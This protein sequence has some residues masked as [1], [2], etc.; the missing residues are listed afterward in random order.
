MSTTCRKWSG[1]SFSAGAAGPSVRVEL[2]LQ[3]VERSQVGVGLPDRVGG[4]E[5]KTAELRERR[6]GYGCLQPR[7][8]GADAEMDADPEGEVT[9]VGAS[10]VEP[11]R[12]D[13]LI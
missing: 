6:Q 7:E 8:R 10:D 11:I 9:I 4:C 3:R 2:E 12:L 13:E 1:S 5:P